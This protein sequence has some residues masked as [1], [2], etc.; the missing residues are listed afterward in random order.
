MTPSGTRL[1]AAALLALIGANAA[2]AQAPPPALSEAVALVEQGDPAGAIAALERQVAEPNAPDI[3]FAALGALLLET[4]SAERALDVLAPLAGREP[5][6]PAALF[7]A[8]RAAEALSRFQD[9]AAYYQRSIEVEPR[10]PALR[11]LGMMIGRLGRAGDSYEYLRAWADANPNDREARLAAAAG[12][13]ALQ[14]LPDAEALIEGLGAQDPPVKL[15]R[16][17]IL[18]LRSDPWGALAELQPLAEAPPPPLERSIRSALAGAYLL[19]GEADRAVEQLERLAPEDPELVGRLARAYFQAGRTED[20]IAAL[21]PF[22]E[23]LVTAPPPADAPRAL[24]R[25]LTYDYGRYLHT[26][27]EAERA[28]P[29]LS[30]A[31]DLHANLP[32]TFQ[33]LAQVLSALGRREEAETAIRRFQD[34]TAAT[35]GPTDPVDAGQR[36][37]DDPTGHLVRQALQRAGSGDANGALEA[38]AREGRLAPDDPRP[39]IAASSVLLHAGRSDEALAAVAQ[40]LDLAP[41]NPDGLYQRGVVLMSLQE[42]G[43]AEEMF[44][45][46]LQASPTH[47][48]TLSDYAVLLMSQGRENEAARHLRRVLELRPDDPL[49]RRHLEQLE[50]DPAPAGGGASEVQSLRRAVEL[51]P[52]DAAAWARLGDALLLERGFRAAE[53]PLRHAVELDPSNVSARIALASSL[54]ENNQAAEA[55]R[56]ALEAATLLPANPAPHRLLGAILL[57]RGEYLKAAESLE[58]SAALAGPDAELHL[59]LARAWEG[60]AG[61][62]PAQA[63]DRLARAE[64]AYRRATTMAPEHHEAVYGLA[65]VLQRLGR[66]EEA[67]AQMARYQTLYDRD[68]QD[69]RERG[70]A[71]GQAPG[72]GE[73][74]PGH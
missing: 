60:A 17:R 28:L 34:L 43:P 45:Q 72:S 27:G 12:A 14:R 40:A 68:Q 51:D 39:A 62:H 63:Q 9:A 56:H 73:P 6:D 33:L 47:V 53:E 52:D 10:S 38:L 23:P 58:R 46:A 29:F 44:R 37:L 7:N 54:W 8:G 24:A 35:S 15:L 49:A 42:L 55:E 74:P 19:V 36:D 70:R 30:L 25:E 21:G 26:T 59:E 5:P 41:G 13:V 50:E 2:P 11:A 67:A 65:Q 1:A 66:T 69:T 32:E 61:Q 18:L 4:G 16:G 3:A 57:W 48:A 71:S 20:A 22:V 64:A 31:A